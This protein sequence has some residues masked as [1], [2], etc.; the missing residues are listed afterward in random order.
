MMSAATYASPLPVAQRQAVIDLPAHGT[1]LRGRRPATNLDDIHAVPM[2]LVR[3]LTDKLSERCVAYCLRKM[4]VAYH[5]THV[6]VFDEHR[7]HL[8]IVR[9]LMRDLV[10]EI[11]TNIPD[12]CMAP[13]DYMLLPVPVLRT[14]LFPGEDTLLTTKAPL[15]LRKGLRATET[16][17]VGADDFA[18]IQIDAD[19]RRRGYHNVT[20]QLPDRGFYKNRSIVSVAGLPADCNVLHPSVERTMQ[21]RLDPLALR[22]GHS[23]TIPV[24]RTM[25]GIVERLPDV[26]ALRDRVLGPMLPPVPESVGALLDGVLQRLGVDLAQPR[27]TLLHRYKLPLRIKIRYAPLQTYPE[28]RHIVQRAIVRDADTTE[29]LREEFGLF[30]CRIETVF[31]RPQHNTN[32]LK[33]IDIHKEK[34][35]DHKQILVNHTH[36]VQHRLSCSILTQIPLQ[37]AALQGSGHPERID[38]KDIHRTWHIHPRHESDAGPRTSVRRSKTVTFHRQNCHADKRIFLVHLTASLSLSST[39]SKPVDTFLLRGNS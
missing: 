28:H 25:L 3:Q 14:R 18:A 16:T 8:A 27:E 37:P 33:S 7:S 13:G 4:M 2:T 15:V 36:D 34:P 22:N 29:A 5:A 10:Q 26:L 38:S 1:T 6:Q 32:I 30:R 20:G 39:L 11:V 24:D 19:A 31:V 23:P 35:M 12:P 9:Q 21:H 17:A